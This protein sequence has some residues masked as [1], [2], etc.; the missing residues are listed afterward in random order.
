MPA[1]SL[2]IA[3]GLERDERIIEIRALA[4]DVAVPT[5]DVTRSQLDRL[6]GG[7]PQAANVH[8]G[9]VL[10]VPP[11]DY[12]HPDDL[13]RRAGEATEP[14]LLVALD[15]VTDP[16]NLGAVA[17]RSEERRVGKECSTQG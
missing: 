11:F 13:V 14:A 10:Q 15:G 4:E 17:R 9:V 1:V 12:L 6:I 8:Q 5:S 2:R 3:G 7:G 16:H